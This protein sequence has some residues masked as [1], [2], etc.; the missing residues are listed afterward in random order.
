MNQGFHI[1][2]KGIG[3]VI[4]RKSISKEKEYVRVW[5]YVPTKVS[6]DT[7]FPFKIGDP[8][9]VE[10]DTAKKSVVVRQ[11]AIDKAHDLGWSRRERYKKQEYA[12]KI[13]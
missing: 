1:A 2:R 11:I 5:I 13:K 6:E 4:G 9:E 8:C 7:A 10:I 3:T 12:G